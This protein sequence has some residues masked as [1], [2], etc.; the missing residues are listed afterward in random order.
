MHGSRDEDVVENGQSAAMLGTP[1][2]PTPQHAPSAWEKA[3]SSHHGRQLGAGVFSTL[4]S[5]TSVLQKVAT[6]VVG[7]EEAN[8]ANK[9]KPHLDLLKTQLLESAQ[10]VETLT[11]ELS[12]YKR[13]LEDKT[14]EC[15][16]L[17]AQAAITS[18]LREELAQEAVARQEAERK[19]MLASAGLCA[20]TNTD[21]AGTAERDAFWAQEVERERAAAAAAA[22]KQV[23][24][25][26]E[27]IAQLE[28]AVEAAQSSAAAA[29]S[30]P[31]PA[32]EGAPDM[33]SRAVAAGQ[34]QQAVASA[35]DAERQ[36]QAELVAELEKVRVS[37]QTS[38]DEF[39][40]KLA[41]LEQALLEEKERNAL[42]NAECDKLKVGVVSV[43]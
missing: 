14:Q 41:S 42:L 3:V 33:V 34:L 1:S 16:M 18:L 27:R 43:G 17:S 21:A 10:E 9:A 13:Q 11:Q 7:A 19:L 28:S 4:S 35:V 38:A 39:T 24:E 31:S 30:T 32:K 6:H 2:T 29:P 37:S 5:A 40:A 15:D 36:R 25:L 26:Q 8:A 22:S 23:Q 12:N 20:G